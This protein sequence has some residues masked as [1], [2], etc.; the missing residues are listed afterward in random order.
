MVLTPTRSRHRRETLSIGFIH[1][2][3]PFV[4]LKLDNLVK[5]TA[6]TTESV[7]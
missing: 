5:V 4:G 7:D 2:L 1:I 6:T 3:V